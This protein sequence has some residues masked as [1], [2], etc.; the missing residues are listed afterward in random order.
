MVRL[1]TTPLPAV[2]LAL[3]ACQAPAKDPPVDNLPFSGLGGTN[4]RLVEIQSMDDSQGTTRP[5]DPAKYTINFGKD[6]SA[7]LRLDCNRGAGNWRNDIANSTG[8]SLEFGPIAV[9]KAYCPPPSLGDALERHLPYV[10]SF[11]IRDGRLNMSLMADGGI[12]VWEQTDG[13]H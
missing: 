10:R 4:W 7:A 6:G 5:D 3:A 12:L 11:V 9:T 2:L 8:G 13:G 1:Q